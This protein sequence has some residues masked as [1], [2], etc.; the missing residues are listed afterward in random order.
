MYVVGTSLGST[1][2]RNNDRD[3]SSTAHSSTGE[4]EE[5]ELPEEEVEVVQEFSMQITS[6]HEVCIACN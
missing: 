4:K 5:R 6:S 1:L 3:S 2:L